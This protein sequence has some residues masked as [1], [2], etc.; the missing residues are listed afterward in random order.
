MGELMDGAMQHA[1]QPGRQS[2]PLILRA[3]ARSW[4]DVLTFQRLRR[5][6]VMPATAARPMDSMAQV[7]GS[8]TAPTVSCGTL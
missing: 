2:M 1:A 5:R 7:P 4:C 6:R 8:G 3:V